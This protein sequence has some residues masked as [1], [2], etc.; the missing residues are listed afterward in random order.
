MEPITL[1]VGKMVELLLRC[2]DIDSRYV[3]RS[4]M[5]DGAKAHRK[6]QKGM[7]KDYQKEVALSFLLSKNDFS[8]LLHGRADGILQTD[9]GI[10]IDE[11]KTTTRPFDMVDDQNILHWAQAKCYGYMYGA[12]LSEP[13]KEITIQL[14]YY[15]LDTEE[16]K[17]YRQT[18]SM[19]ELKFFVEDLIDKYSALLAYE[20]DWREKR[21]ASLKELAFPFDTY[22]KGQRSM[23][24]AV[25]RA[26]REEKQLF[27]NAPTGI[28]KTLSALFPAAKAMGEGL[29]DKLF[30]LTS[31]T[32]TR[33]VAQDAIQLMADRQAPF[34]HFKVLTLTAKD[35][36]CFCE[37][38]ICT[39][40]HCP[41]AKGHFDRVGDAIWDALAAE[42]ALTREIIEEYAKKHSVCPYEFSLDL[43]L[44]AD[45]VICDYNYVFDPVVY[46]RRFFGEEAEERRYV[47]LA[48]EAHN[49][50]ERA[51]D[52]HSAE[53]TKSQV[54]ECIKLLSGQKKSKLYKALQKVNKYF[55]E[56]KKDLAP[57]DKRAETDRPE[58]LGELL[59]KLSPPVE[60]WLAEHEG[61]EA[62]GAMLELYFSLLFFL[63]IWENYDDCYRTLTWPGRDV[64][65]MLFCIDPAGRLAQRCQKAISS[66]FFS[67]TMAPLLFYKDVL[68]GQ[69][70]AGTMALPSPF[71]PQKLTLTVED[72]VSVKY[73]FR[74]QNIPPIARCIYNFTQKNQGNSIVY[75][76]SY[77]YMEQVLAF[78]T[79]Q[80]PHMKT[81]CQSVGM[82][83]EEREDFLAAFDGNN[84]ET[85][86]GFCV[87]GGIFSEGVDLTGDRLTGAVIVGVGLPKISL[88]QDV[89]RDYFDEKNGRGY[90]YA[91]LYPG[92]NKVLQAAGRVIRREE[93]EGA[94]L[95]IDE[96]FTTP[97][98]L[99]LF[100][101]HWRHFKREE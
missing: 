31:K 33:Q 10:T 29:C 75:F 6:I 93:D 22:R 1:S 32:I 48:D 88:R 51:R 4:A 77:S 28:G 15:Q 53:L 76:P 37:E 84:R 45:C 54:Y 35:K 98:Y 23:A 94:V 47:F 97:A 81:I 61:H 60:E 70:E 100:P 86:L 101:A 24:A 26:V 90:D 3:S 11:I 91:Y 67:A 57:A 40:D 66:V 2:G 34:F 72:R 62:H 68:G 36:I 9:D 63:E 69:E 95:L 14:T 5:L 96:R 39:P 87:L 46:L 50:L 71:D 55:I 42:N 82:T 12:Q 41:Y 99:S 18:C 27:I 74:E 56:L 89:I 19:E 58:E 85:L 17:R 8:V 78:F 16:L 44:W 73:R 92:M 25:F 59:Y 83:E 43:S 80:Y 21:N 65:V 38:R 49:L 20:R 30:Y 79:E 13:V 64:T 52:M 7:G